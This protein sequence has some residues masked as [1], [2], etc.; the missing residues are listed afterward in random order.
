MQQQ[1][2][3]GVAD[4]LA[5]RALT[6]SKWLCAFAAVPPLV[7]LAGWILNVEPL[8]RVYSTFPLAWPNTAL[9][10]ILSTIAVFLTCVSGRSRARS[11]AACV[12]GSL[13]LGYGLFIL[14]EYIWRWQP[15]I[16]RLLLGSSRL[17][18]VPYA[19]RPS[20]Q[21][22]GNLIVLG[23]SVIVYNV[24]RL[25]IRAGQVGALIAGANAIVAL[26]GYIFN[27]KEF[28]GFPSLNTEIGMSIHTATCC[29]LLALALLCSRPSEGM[30]T[31]VT[32]D[33]LSGGMARK[34][35]L[36][37]G[38][39]P[40]VI[41]VITRLGVFA[42]WYGV[43]VQ[44]SLFVIG[45][46]AMV[47][48]TT[49]RAAR[50]SERGELRARD[51]LNQVSIANE[52][53]RLSEAKYSGIVSL[54]ADGI[55]SIDAEQNITLF[56]EG[57]QKIFGYSKEEVIGAPLEML[58][59]K[60]LRAA[61]RTYVTGFTQGEES[62]RRMNRRSAAIVG[63]RKNGE[64]FPADASISKIDVDGS[65]VA[66]VALRDITLQKRV[67]SEQRFLAD[68]GAILTSSLD[69]DEML[70]HIA[71]LA[72][73]DIADFCMV[74]A[75]EKDGRVKR[76]KVFPREV[77]NKPIC[78]LFMA[79]SAGNSRGSLFCSVVEEKRPL[80]IDHLLPADLEALSQDE[81]ERRALLAAGVQS[82]VA[83]PLLVHENLVGM[84]VLM[85][86]SQFQFYGPA[87]LRLAE[88]LAQRTALAILN[89]TL[90]RKAE[91][92]VRAREEMLTIVSHDLRNPVAAIS[93]V[94]HLLRQSEQIDSGRLTDLADKTQRAVDRMQSLISDLLDFGKMESGTFSVEK[95]PG[96]LDH[97]VVGVVDSMKLLAEAKY[98][99]IQIDLLPD[100]P[101]V[102]M[103][104]H[105]VSQVISNLLGN[106]IKFT[107]PYGA[108]RISAR[109]QSNSVV[110]S[111]T[112]TGPGIAPENL[113]KVF[114]RFWRVQETK[115][116]GSGLGLSIA[117][118]IVEAH[119]GRIWAESE[120]GKGSSFLFTLPLCGLDTF[121]GNNAA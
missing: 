73:R 70:G 45:I 107:P 13:A 116:G 27:T 93:L 96:G 51:A 42:K 56:N 104:T 11:L 99:T 3:I 115:Q 12:F 1:G 77:S 85:S 15:G 43:G 103:D 9:G 50:L 8:V 10:L 110:V 69:C 112:D 30:M 82:L 4:L 89:I 97:V 23:A 90:L 19:G 84:I 18:D 72:V 66:T 57:A 55:I 74:D 26:T 53:L 41:G 76:V 121:P 71:E 46:A 119:G 22:A 91:Q 62:A 79:V 86:S 48:S 68:V 20:P 87:H 111:V 38:L 95:H 24:R 118:G 21:T 114:E 108:V 49:W 39:A 80:L 37:V 78:E 92:A 117:R 2:S 25:P 31:L 34:I 113:S 58:L 5:T 65:Q 105:R 7:A 52:K 101:E 32:S 6:L 64:E 17:R 100:L 40:L 75:V 83:V 16:D 102:A 120:L 63:L 33:T 47:L 44:V 67:E 98:Q 106:A 61:H 28:Y 94:G 36:T 35:L 14:G 88:E 59:P 81:R 60:R 29:I 54:S 109:R